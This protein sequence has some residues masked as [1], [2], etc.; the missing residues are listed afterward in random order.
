M[1]NNYMFWA[2]QVPSAIVSWICA[3]SLI[4]VVVK[5]T[6]EVFTRKNKVKERD[7]DD[8]KRY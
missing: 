4:S 5:A 2:I 7:K 3:I 1:W 6:Y 8:K